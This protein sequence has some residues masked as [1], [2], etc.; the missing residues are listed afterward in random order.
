MSWFNDTPTGQAVKSYVK[1]FVSVV[2]GMFLADGA[3]VFAVD[4]TDVR[5][6]AS[7]GIAAVVPLVLTALDSSDPRFGRGSDTTDTSVE[8]FDSEGYKG[9]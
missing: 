6:W 5:S 4:M 9:E 2:L 3:D 1:V 8:E 7:A